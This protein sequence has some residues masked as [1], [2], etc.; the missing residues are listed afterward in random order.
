MRPNT[1]PQLWHLACG[2]AILNSEYNGHIVAKWNGRIAMPQLV[3]NGAMMQC[4]FGAAPA[5]L[6]VTPVNRVNAG[7]QPAANIMDHKPMM[8]IAPFGMT[9]QPC[10]P[11][12]NSPWV[13]GS[14][15]V[16]IAGQPALNSTCT[17]N[18]MWAGVIK[19]NLPGQF[20]VN[21]GS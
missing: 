15:T 1:L 14:M 11:A 10:I 18:C 17:C 8:N 5:T 13:P 21:V 16:M 3:V 7:G 12:T 9:P 6:T 2:N 4:S 20:T 19:I